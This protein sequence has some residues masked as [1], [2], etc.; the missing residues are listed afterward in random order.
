MDTVDSSFPNY[1]R[2][3]LSEDKM[4]FLPLL[5]LFLTPVNDCKH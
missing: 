2:G 1:G 5:G 3:S 4:D